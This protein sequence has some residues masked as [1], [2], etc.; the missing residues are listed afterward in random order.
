M[1]A[2]GFVVLPEEGWRVWRAGG[3]A[4]SGR[5]NRGGGWGGVER[6]SLCLAGICREGRGSN[7]EG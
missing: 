6:D 7:G 3:P 1:K 5:L 2:Y 4:F